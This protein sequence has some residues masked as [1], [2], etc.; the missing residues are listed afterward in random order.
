MENIFNLLL[1]PQM[2][3]SRFC[4]VIVSVEKPNKSG[5]AVRMK[6]VCFAESDRFCRRAMKRI[7][8]Y[9]FWWVAVVLSCWTLPV[10]AMYQ[11]SPS[12][13]SFSVS[14]NPF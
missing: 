7:K 10:L 4:F 9:E 13:A 12:S 5:R 14:V 1:S 2:L 8:S 3:L 6:S 11:N